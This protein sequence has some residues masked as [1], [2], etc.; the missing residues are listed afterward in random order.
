MK[1]GKKIWFMTVRTEEHVHAQ[2]LGFTKQFYAYAYADSA[3]EAA[4]VGV[5]W[6]AEKKGILCS[7]K[8]S[9]CLPAKQQAFD[10]Y[11][12]PHQI[13]NI[14]VDVLNAIY[15]KRNY[16]DNYRDPAFRV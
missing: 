13:I 4:A 5:K 14:P 7:V 1:E 3:A 11:T 16:P 2:A 9:E 8:E 10:T 6:Y 15:D 12:F